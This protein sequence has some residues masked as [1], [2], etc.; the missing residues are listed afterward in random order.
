MKD[1]LSKREEREQIKNIPKTIKKSKSFLRLLDFPI[2]SY[3][4]TP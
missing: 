4:S 1:E 3:F 2:F